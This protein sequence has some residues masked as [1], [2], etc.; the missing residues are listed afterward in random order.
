M[1]DVA[2]TMVDFLPSW[3]YAGIQSDPPQHCLGEANSCCEA[4]PPAV[5]PLYTITSVSLGQL[6][7]SLPRAAR[8]KCSQNARGVVAA[9]KQQGLNRASCPPACLWSKAA[10]RQQ[11]HMQRQRSR[12]LAPRRLLA[13]C[14]G[15][16]PVVPTQCWILR[17]L[18]QGQEASGTHGR[19]APRQALLSGG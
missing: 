17:V 8:E 9:Y 14:P 15:W 16:V 4:P 11:G 5:D 10:L 3:R 18:G 1:E 2:G 6:G 12:V 19:P 7:A 13:P